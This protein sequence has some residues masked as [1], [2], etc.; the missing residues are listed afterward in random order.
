[1]YVVKGC[2]CD[3]EKEVE[4]S[5]VPDVFDSVCSAYTVRNR[6]AGA[7]YK[8]VAVE[9]W[10][11]LRARQAENLLLTMA[12]CREMRP[13]WRPFLLC[14][15]CTVRSLTTGAPFLSVLAE[16]WGL[17]Q[18]EEK[19]SSACKELSRFR[20]EMVNMCGMTYKFFCWVFWMPYFSATSCKEVLYQTGFSLFLLEFWV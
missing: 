7:T 17:M 13:D 1:M 14:G 4:S 12:G 9:V 8:N 5:E 16:K 11:V 20:W 18:G 6:V 10:E 2:L 19:E 3:G 15:A